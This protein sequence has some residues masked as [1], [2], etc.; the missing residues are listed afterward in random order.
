MKTFINIIFALLFCFLLSSCGEKWT[1][2]TQAK[3]M[4]SMSESGKLGSADKG[5]SCDEIR[6]FELRVYGEVDEDALKN[7]FGC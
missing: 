3:T 7:D 4:F 6:S 1:C 2:V 5:C